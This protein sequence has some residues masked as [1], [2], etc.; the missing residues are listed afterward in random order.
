[1]VKTKRTNN[2]AQRQRRVTRLL[3][4]RRGPFPERATVTKGHND[5]HSHENASD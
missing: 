4:E 3:A 2:D 1:M 5:E